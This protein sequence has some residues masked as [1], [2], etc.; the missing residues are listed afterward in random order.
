MTRACIDHIHQSGVE[1]MGMGI[2]GTG[3]GT[4][5]RVAALSVVEVPV[6]T[7]I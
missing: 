2:S 1:Y 7:A 5:V 4:I 6:A 3:L